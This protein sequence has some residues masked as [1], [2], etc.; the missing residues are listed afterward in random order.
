[1]RRCAGGGL[2]GRWREVGSESSPRFAGGTP[3]M[4]ADSAMSDVD[5][6]LAPAGIAVIGM[7]GRFPGAASVGELWLQ[8]RAGVCGISFLSDE[9][10]AA[11]GVSAAEREDPRYVRAAGVL[12]EAER[13][14][15]ELFG[16][17]PREAEVMDPQ[18]RVFLECAWEALEDAGH[19]PERF[20]GWIGV[21]AG[22]A[23]GKYLWMNVAR[24]PEA[25][26]A[27]GTFQAMISNDK[28]YLPTQASYRLNL[29]GPSIGVQTACSTSLVAVHLAC[30]GLIGGECDLALA[31]GVAVSV[32]E[33]RGYRFQ[34]LSITS[35]DGY[36]RPFDAR[37][38]GT[39]RSNGAGIVVL[40][41]L[42]DAL[43]AG[44]RVLA[45]IRG[46]AI[47]ND[48]AAKVGYTAPS[49]TGQA[50]VIAAAQAVA[51]VSP[52]TIGYVEAHGTA[53]ALGDPIEVAALSQ[54]FGAAGG[55]RRGFCALGSVKGNLGHLDAAA[56]VAG[57]IKTVLALWHGELPPSLHYETPNPQID[58]AASPFYVNARLQPWPAGKEPRRAGVSA[59]G[60]GGTNAHVVLEEAPGPAA[61][62]K[63]R[64][65]LAAGT[66]GEPGGSPPL[67]RPWHL[68][69]LSARS[70]AALRAAAA[71]LAHHLGRPS[72]TAEPKAQGA[73]AP[74]PPPVPRHAALPEPLQAAPPVRLQATVSEP[75]QAVRRELLQ[76]AASESHQ[77]AAS[78][79]HQAVPPEPHQAVPPELHQAVPPEILQA[80]ASEPH[81]ATTAG[82]DPAAEDLA[83]VA[84]TLQV[85]R[86]ALGWRWAA[87]AR[88]R[89]EACA[90]LVEAAQDGA[91]TAVLPGRPAVAFVFPGQGAQFAGM[92][93]DLYRGEAVFRAAVEEC[94]DLFGPPLGGEVQRWVTAG[95]AAGDVREEAGAA[96]HQTWLTQPALFVCEHALAR[97][98][99]SW[100]VAPAALLGHSVGELV[101]AALAGVLPL[102]AALRL[103][104][105]RGRL[106]QAL[107]AGSMM[108][109][110]LAEEA[111]RPRLHGDLDLAVVNG[112]RQCVV[113]G[114][115][116]AVA[117]LAAELRAEGLPVRLLR[118]SH[119]FHSRMMEPILEELQR[120]V[121]AE[122]LEEPRIACVSS[123]TGRWV[124]TGEATDP[125][126]WALQARAPVRFGA[127]LECLL[128]NPGRVLLE[129][130]P[131]QG[132]RQLVRQLAE[133]RPAAAPVPV[134]AGLRAPLSG[135]PGPGGQ[136]QVLRALGRLWEHG[137]AVDWQGFHGA[138]R[139][140]R[141]ALPTYPFERQRYYLAGAGEEGA[142]EASG[143]HAADAGRRPLRDWFYLPSWE[144][145]LAPSPRA[146]RPAALEESA[147]RRCL[148][149][150]DSHGLGEA[151]GT[152]L[153][154]GGWQVTTVAAGDE[155]EAAGPDRYRM[156]PGDAAGHL[157]LW[158]ELAA[159]PGLPR[160]VLHLWNVTAAAG[161]AGEHAENAANAADTASAPKTANAENA[162]NTASAENATNTASAENATNTANADNAA[163]AESAANT[164]NTENAADTA[165]TV[166]V[167]HTAETV[168]LAAALDRAFYSL[169]HLAHGLGRH[170]AALSA[171]VEVFVFANHLHAVESG[172]RPEPG[173]A[174]LLG[175][176][177]VMP[178]ELDSVFCRVID[179]GSGD[180]LSAH[181]APADRL[182]VRCL[183]E[184]ESPAG[185][186]M[187]AW[188]GPNRWLPSW[189]AVPL[190]PV[191]AVAP[192]AA[193][194]AG[195]R[196]QGVYLITGGLGG[197]GLEI[198][199]HL[200]A[201]VSARLVLLGRTPLP[202]PGL[203]SSWLAAHPAQDDATSATIR[204]LQALEALGAELLVVA[205]DV[206]DTARMAEVRRLAVARFGAV[207]GIFHAAGVAGG[208]LLETRT[209]ERAAAVLAPKVQGTQVLA[210]VFGSVGEVGGVGRV[211]GVGNVGR[212][213]NVGGDLELL[214]L[215]SSLA[216]LSGGIGQADY[217]AAN[218]FQDSFAATAGGAG[219]GAGTT[220][221]VAIDWDAWQQVGM[222]A[223]ADVPPELRAWHSRHLDE[224]IQPGEGREAL[225]RILASEASQVAV[226]T[227]PLGP[228]LAAAARWRLGAALRQGAAP[229]TAR[230]RHQRPPSAVVYAP[231]VTPIERR[232]VG[233]WQELLGI[234]PIG[235]DD[236]FFELGGHSLLA[237]QLAAALRAQL[238][239]E[240][241]L[242]TIVTH[243]TPA[244]LAAALARAGAEA[245]PRPAAASRLVALQAE[246]ARPP[247]FCVH[248]AGGNTVADVELAERLG[249][250]QP[251]YA[252]QSDGLDDDL[253]DGLA[254]ESMAAR[255]VE[256][257]RDV[258]ARGPFHLGGWSMGG[259][260][261]YEMAQQLHAAGERVALL[262]LFDTRAYTRPDDVDEL[263]EDDVEILFALYGPDLD[264]SLAEM[265][266]LPAAA[267]LPHVIERGRRAGLL[268]AD[269]GP[270]QARRLLT[271]YKRN[272][273]LMWDYLPRPYPGAMVLLQA[274]ERRRGEE[275]PLGLGWDELVRGGLRT[276]LVP[277]NH[278]NL[279]AA[280][281]VAAVAA[282][283]SRLLAGLDPAV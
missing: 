154:A 205:G 261:A 12:G 265:Q 52:G 196:P 34:Q 2:S 180:P 191:P 26:A 143:D 146:S 188:R 91:A 174:A 242:Q 5:L 176:C 168:P 15:A 171:G 101:A 230:S 49:V 133:S 69:V 108:A 157:R 30:Q 50:E 164:A 237:I 94:C 135:Q 126:Y 93:A 6:D 172:D 41:R 105:L 71:R 279:M 31:G 58:F 167:A 192:G 73:P 95:A 25:L 250:S 46:S 259:L 227:V 42:G 18:L 128:E 193:E 275:P 155:F 236:D 35:P 144:R 258:Q 86:R 38:A 235:R 98:W 162:T 197:L 179:I 90:R 19:D 211:G 271:V 141:V 61:A 257:I 32:P 209:A 82:A 175:P 185:D 47:N 266:A 55:G 182:V 217:A 109:V 280:P 48:G 252:V 134:V 111:L 9:E 17:T 158:N 224:A 7:S 177:R 62:V 112:P 187:V 106:M 150:A 78:E 189:K 203:W 79:S 21:Y 110:A 57:L 156:H 76:A 276:H 272:R 225:A 3:G 67:A 264:L 27:V 89:A 139:R 145:S 220:R 233:L 77:A 116:P 130:G 96:L 247:F 74:A 173:K 60:I 263:P 152:R 120:A 169:L 33:R 63:A 270:E 84:Y 20:A 131:R 147:N 44:D 239:V 160:R 231:P 260:V 132:L 124:R 199:H 165:T 219:A 97:L 104:A 267:V 51:G 201:S 11:A 228:R 54:A 184:M 277:G 1:M 117:A 81:E 66:G 28:D 213:G 216:A 253:I 64:R 43:A 113:S 256:A 59:F 283:M 198:A 234:E 215:C 137:V 22:A 229:A 244:R 246:G 254:V 65:D 148:I 151:L 14:D 122:P 262:V 68:L 56:G 129:V 226:S 23:V 166:T 127:A 238:A 80:V 222:A 207:H 4:A 214:V 221:V 100:G 255:Y 136:E 85:G 274:S 114:P 102:A 75:H 37:A 153:R 186:A 240:A 39:L 119:A 181:G 16:L 13:F 208:G 149:L 115:E 223:A 206:T 245:P 103:V 87:P 190:P 83:D 24:H 183:A 161:A 125:R 36:C 248:P 163:N 107:P 210:Q 178:Q 118:T 281:H 200:A 92:G 70:E 88:S 99:M 121:A 45:V 202:E 72:G 278:N 138:G 268:A 243:S 29:R 53:T 140:Q 204:R 10:L 249:P 170:A 123:V 195:L 142:A 282:A 269:F 159:G 212:V 241:P 194:A 218:A 8:L 232:L 273:R 251:F 40:R